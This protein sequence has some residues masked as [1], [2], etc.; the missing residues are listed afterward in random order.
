MQLFRH[1]G[2]II[3]LLLIG[4]TVCL[5]A[6]PNTTSLPDDIFTD[7]I[8]PDSL[9]G[10]TIILLQDTSVP[11]IFERVKRI[12]QKSGVM[13]FRIQIYNGSGQDAREAIN[14]LT[15]E[16]LAKFPDIDPAVIYQEYQAPF[17]KLR[18]GD[19]R[20]RNEAFQLYNQIKHYFPNCYI[21]KSR[22]NYPKLYADTRPEPMRN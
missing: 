3:T 1:K 7:L 20:T 9:T 18:I 12:N 16:F 21:V 14:K 17:F 5:W 8:K 6:Q 22:I 10:A 15:L 4:F 2:F 19:F 13:G 11:A